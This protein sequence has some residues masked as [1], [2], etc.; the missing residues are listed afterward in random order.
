MNF[1]FDSDLDADEIFKHPQLF[2]FLTKIV[3][4]DFF[5]IFIVTNH[6]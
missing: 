5:I 6:S 3:K 2:T 4:K 1:D